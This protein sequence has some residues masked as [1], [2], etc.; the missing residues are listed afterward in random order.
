MSGPPVGSEFPPRFMKGFEVDKI[1]TGGTE[2]LIQLGRADRREILTIESPH[3]SLVVRRLLL[4][5]S[6]DIKQAVG[7]VLSA[8][9]RS[10]AAFLLLVE[11]DDLPARLR[12]LS[13]QVRKGQRM[14]LMR[15]I[16]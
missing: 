8:M 1:I 4:T 11:H 16:T 5:K 15:V 6:H 12:S 7:G 9:A 14:K 3:C 2:S 10:D 13:N